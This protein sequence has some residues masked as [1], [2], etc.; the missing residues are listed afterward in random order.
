MISRT[1]LKIVLFY[2]H[3]G[4]ILK[5]FNFYWDPK[6]EQL[7]LA[8]TNPSQKK[9]LRAILG[10]Q[11]F[12]IVMRLSFILLVGGN[13]IYADASEAVVGL[14]LFSIWIYTIY[15]HIHFFR[16]HPELL[17][18]TNALLNINKYAGMI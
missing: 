16:Y 12:N 9:Y 14:L 6:T 3:L 7:V 10:Y 11:V 5:V 1:T 17:R 8:R 15:I 13:L 4:F 18:G 2:I